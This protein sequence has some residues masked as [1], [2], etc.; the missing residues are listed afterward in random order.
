VTGGSL[1]GRRLGEDG[2]ALIVVLLLLA[3]LLTIVGEFTQ[4]MRMEAVTAANFRAGI[5]ETWLAEAAYQR[6]LAEILPEALAHEL[7][8]EGLL[9]FR[10]TRLGTPTVPERLDVGLDPGRL[11]YR[12]TDESARI[13]LNRATRDVLDRLLQDLG[14]EKTDRDTIIDSIQ[15]WRDPNEEHRLNGAESDY[16]L[17]LPVPYRSKNGD[18][19][20]VDELLQVRGMTR[21]LLYGR[22]DAP[23]LAEHLTVFGAAVTNLN[24][25][26][27]VVLRALGFAPAEVDFIVAR[28]PWASPAEIP[29][30]FRRG[31]QQTRTQIFRIE[32]WAGGATPSGRVLTTVVERQGGTGQ[33]QGG[34]GETQGGTGQ[35]QGETGRAQAGIGQAQGGTRQT[36]GGTRQTQGGTGQT[37]GRT[38]RAQ[39]GIGQA[40]GGTRQTRGGPGQTQ[41]GTGQ[42]QS[43]TGQTQSGTG[44][45]QGGS[46]LAQAGI[47]QA[48]AVPLVWRWSEASRPTASTPPTAPSTGGRRKGP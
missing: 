17:G 41:G 46:G 25:A 47:G 12:I 15:D 10:R 16:Y 30:P 44:Q 20:S 32:A 19:N 8:V 22:P 35:T 7:D 38:G 45:T 43:G 27:P 21:E 34:T 1:A 24:T 4:A 37:L 5:A 6:A 31:R 3:L 36:Q 14:A 18:F 40:Q 2:V 28:R 26:S 11:S 9:S 42:T 48:Q 29:V 23:G 39:A 33:M 13:N